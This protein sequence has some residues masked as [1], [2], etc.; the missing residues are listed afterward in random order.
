VKGTAGDIA[1]CLDTEDFGAGDA[2]LLRLVDKLRTMHPKAV[3]IEYFGGCRPSWVGTDPQLP[4]PVGPETLAKVREALAEMGC[5]IVLYDWDADL[6]P[7][8]GR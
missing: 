6:P 8:Q 2:A 4:F 5:T 1:F 3:R 7:C